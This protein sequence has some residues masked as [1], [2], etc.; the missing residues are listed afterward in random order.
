MF[1]KNTSAKRRATGAA[2]VAVGL[3]LVL[4]GCGG[5]DG[6]TGSADP[7]EGGSAGVERDLAIA[8]QS[9]PNSFDPAQ[10]VDG[11]QMFAWTAVLDTLLARD[12]ETG[13]LVPSAA[14]SWEYNEDGT[15]LTLV[16]R[17]DMTFSDGSQVDANAVATTMKRTMETPGAVQSKYADVSDIVAADDYTV[18]VHF[19]EHDPQFIYNISLGAGAIG[20][21]DTLDDERTETDPIG[22]GPYTLDTANTVPGTTY[23]FKKRDDYWN[24]DAIEVETFTI[25]VLQD[26]TASF[27]ALQAGEID[28]ANVRPQMITQLNEEDFTFS[29]IDAT[30]LMFLDIVD[31]S[32]EDFPALGDERVRQALNYAVN[33]EDMVSGLL[34]GQGAPATQIFNPEGEVHDPALDATYEYDPEK[35]KELVEEAGYA[36]ETIEIPSTFLST[37]F[38]PAI[39]QAFTDAGLNVEWVSVPPQQAQSAHLSGDYGVTFQILG[40]NSDPADAFYHFSPG[41]FG[42]PLNH[43][44]EK[45]DE[46]FGTIN[47]TVD[48]NDAVDAYRELNEYAVEEAF[49]VP[50]VTTG[51][52]WAG[53]DGISFSTVGGLPTTIRAFDFEG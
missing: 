23:V 42:N 32:G 52:T 33:R 29:E 45:L 34:A 10:V 40:F 50:L 4:A 21:P 43:S 24:A 11:Q 36:G 37:N 8:V 47:T 22:S 27:N 17:D 20:H 38:E 28:A 19:G 14:E 41:G 49:V 30:A 35:A 46:L 2:A 44:D 6:G 53:R 48:F 15:V 3:S 9:G 12:S 25:R 16:L 18:E 13:E 51:S 1:W 7:V 5:G 31:R 39:S 26:P